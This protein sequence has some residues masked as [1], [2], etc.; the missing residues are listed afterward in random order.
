MKKKINNHGFSLVELIVIMIIIV[1]LATAVVV[2]FVNTADQKVKA[3]STLISKYLD[4]TLSTS[5]TKGSAYMTIRYDSGKSS[6]YVEDG[7]GHSEKLS[8][9]VNVTYDIENGAEGQL[10]NAD[11]PLMLTYSR[12]N[13]EGPIRVIEVEKVYTNDKPIEKITVTCNDS[14]KVIKLY[15]KTGMYEIE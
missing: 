13:G 10:I 15:T 4:S 11:N 7:V 5:M 2:A 9:G 14:S 1:I 12:I 8:S 3:S 6:Y